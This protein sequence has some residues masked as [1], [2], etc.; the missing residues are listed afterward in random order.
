MNDQAYLEQR[1][2]KSEE[3]QVIEKKKERFACLD[4]FR[5]LTM[6]GMILVDSQGDFS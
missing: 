6:M 2:Y 3:P 1:L 5:G 4:V